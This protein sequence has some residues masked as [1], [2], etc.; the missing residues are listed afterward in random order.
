MFGEKTTFQGNLYNKN[1][2][3]INKKI[4]DKEE[5]YFATREFQ[6]MQTIN[7]GISSPQGIFGL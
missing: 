5:N 6:I 2:F 3:F 4:C 7:S 1:M